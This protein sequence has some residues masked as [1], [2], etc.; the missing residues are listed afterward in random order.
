MTFHDELNSLYRN[1][2]T[3][4]EHEQEVVLAATRAILIDL[5][6]GG[7]NKVSE[8]NL[9]HCVM[10]H[11]ETG[12]VRRSAFEYAFSHAISELKDEG[13]KF[14]VRMAENAVFY[15]WD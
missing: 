9:K 10:C 11:D 5:A 1:A 8:E 13:L 15:F 6:K 7:L 14:G 4:T 3:A 12:E 2:T